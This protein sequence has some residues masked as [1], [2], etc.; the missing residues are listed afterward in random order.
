M[1]KKEFKEL[2]LK[3]TEWTIPFGKESTLEKYLPSG[4]KKDSVGNYF[5]Q[6]GESRT[7]FTTHLD[8]Y[9]KD[10]EKVNHVFNEKDPYIIKTD[11]KTIL[12]GDN[13][14]GCCILISMIKDNIPGT[15]YFFIGEE[16]ILSGGLYGSSEILELNSEFFQNFDRCIA[17]DRK[18]YGSIVVRQMGR[19]CC[20]SEFAKSIANEFNIKGIKWD[21]TKGFGYY[22]DTAVFMDVIPE[23]TNISAG[24]FNEHFTSEWIDLNYTYNVYLAAKDLDWESLPTER[25]IEERFSEEESESKVK[26]FLGF[27]NKKVTEEVTK[28]LTI[29]DLSLTRDLSK[30]GTRHLTFSKWL[31]DYDL[32]IFIKSGTIMINN[33]KMN[34]SQ[35]KSFIVKEFI[36]EIQDEINYLKRQKD[37]KAVDNIMNSFNLPKTFSSE[38]PR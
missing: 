35:F 26:R 17:F 36:D 28:L 32:D 18:E 22:T 16:P 5:Y 29:I 4:F 25:I 21:S 23:C 20:S 38:S 2:F 7:L 27:S 34:L 9:S 19:M 24:G 31:E 12:G 14:L 11:G 1:D 30:D 15:Y 3:L 8:T 6:V 10:Y 33:K 13:K 37:F